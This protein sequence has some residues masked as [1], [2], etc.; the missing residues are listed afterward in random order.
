MAISEKQQ[1]I[2]LKWLGNIRRKHWSDRSE[3]ADWWDK[4][5]PEWRGVVLHAAGVNSGSDVFKAALSRCSWRELFERLDYRAM[6]QLRQ[7]I[8]HAR[9]TF[10]GFGSLR[11]SDFSRRTAAR[12]E[13]RKQ[14]NPIHNS[15]VQM[16]VA[17]NA[18]FTML[19]K[20]QGV[21]E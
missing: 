19:A 5:T 1:K 10:E 6:I 15:E 7:G 14:C 17:P 18:V 20:Q 12:P 21:Q 9:I 3:A 11:D 4:L 16:V 8:S 13:P 2:A